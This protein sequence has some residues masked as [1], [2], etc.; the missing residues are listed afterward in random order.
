M[1]I[2]TRGK[3]SLEALLYLA[4]LPEGDFA[5]TR[6]ISEKTGI[7]DGYLEQL[8]IP[9]KKAGVIRGI[10]GAQ[11]GYLP[12]RPIN[13]I[14]VGQIL[15]AVEGS[16]EPVACLSSGT[17]PAEAKCITRHTWSALYRE[18]ADCVDSI[19][20]KDLVESYNTLDKEEYV[21]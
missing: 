11:G 1:R 20:L 18:I 3:Y 16:L 8:F 9:L 14:Y 6:S 17:C 4:L 21:I 12:G 7:S 5:S 10:R 13:E 2:S 15:R 19:S